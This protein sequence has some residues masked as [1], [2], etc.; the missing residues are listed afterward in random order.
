MML[1]A[2]KLSQQWNVLGIWPPLLLPAVIQAI[3][4]FVRMDLS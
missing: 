1:R 4:L 3:M 2:V